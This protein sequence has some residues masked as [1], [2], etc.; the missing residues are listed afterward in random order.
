MS[1]CDRYREQVNAYVAG[2]LDDDERAQLEDHV[3]GCPACREELEAARRTWSSLDH[4]LDARPPAD[5]AERALDRHRT[6]GRVLRIVWPTA[7]AAAIALGLFI[8]SSHRSRTG[9]GPGPELPRTPQAPLIADADRE[10]IEMLDLLEEMPMLAEL[11][12]VQSADMLQTLDRLGLVDGH[13]EEEK[14]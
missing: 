2:M 6:R 7:A 4:W 10:V 12:L 13:E 11:D 14:S 3:I 5:L 8:W 1:A 9:V